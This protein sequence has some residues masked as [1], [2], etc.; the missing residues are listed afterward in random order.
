MQAISKLSM[1]S[2]DTGA[3]DGAAKAPSKSQEGRGCEEIESKLESSHCKRDVTEIEEQEC[4][5]DEDENKSVSSSEEEDE[6]Y[7]GKTYNGK[8]LFCISP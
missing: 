5:D 2:I 3:S 1:D 6:S 7:I 8:T 4:D